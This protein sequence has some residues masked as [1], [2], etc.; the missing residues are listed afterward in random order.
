MS[1]MSLMSLF[2]Q[3]EW[4]QLN[5]TVIPNRLLLT[6]YADQDEALLTAPDV[7]QASGSPS[8]NASKTRKTR[9]DDRSKYCQFLL[10]VE[11]K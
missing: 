3:L 8:L 6:Y 9:R 7:D 1:L 4:Q 11:R 10:Q 5:V 2:I